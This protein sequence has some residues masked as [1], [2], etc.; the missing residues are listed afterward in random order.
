VGSSKDSIIQ[1]VLERHKKNLQVSVV[2]E[3]E[4]INVGNL[5]V[6]TLLRG[7]NCAKTACGLCSQFVDSEEELRFSHKVPILLFRFVR[8][9]IPFQ[10]HSYVTNFSAFNFPVLQPSIGV[11]S[12]F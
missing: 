1:H 4:E 3:P 6:E 8:S 7:D 11:R 10:L 2:E 12:I 9:S 5:D